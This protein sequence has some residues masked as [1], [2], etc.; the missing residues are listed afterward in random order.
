MPRNEVI[1]IKTSKGHKVFIMEI[2]DRIDV[3]APPLG[4]YIIISYFDNGE[5]G[6]V[7]FLK[8]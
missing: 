8:L 1:S 4:A 6:K 7:K 5:I 3:S 2:D